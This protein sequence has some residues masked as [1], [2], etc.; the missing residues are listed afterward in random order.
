MSSSFVAKHRFASVYNSNAKSIISY[1]LI[2]YGRPANTNLQNIEMVQRRIIRAIFFKKKRDSIRD[3]LR[4]TE[5][6]TVFELIIVDVFWDIFSQLRSDEKTNLIT[7]LGQSK[8]TPRYETRR[9]KKR[10]STS[11]DEPNKN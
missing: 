6:Y 2:V 4:D 5:V 9:S 8:I 11:I 10:F 7:R 1:G 3:I